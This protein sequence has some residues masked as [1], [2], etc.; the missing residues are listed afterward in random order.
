MAFCTIIH[1]YRPDLIHLNNLDRSQVKENNEL[2]F[3]VAEVE[4]GIPA[5]L[6]VDDMVDMRAPDRFCVVTYVS[7]YY[8]YFK[9]KIPPG[10]D[11]E[12]V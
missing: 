1:H 10:S 12:R 11:C 6:S 9:D 4:L 7:Q 8:H 3:R 5:L 2:A